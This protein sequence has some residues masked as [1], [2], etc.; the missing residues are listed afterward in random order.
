M[1]DLV[2]FGYS[3]NLRAESCFVLQ[4]ILSFLHQI[5]KRLSLDFEFIFCQFALLRRLDFSTI[6]PFY[7]FL[8]LK[9]FSFPCIDVENSHNAILIFAE[10]LIKIELLQSRLLIAFI[11]LSSLRT[12]ILHLLLTRVLLE[13]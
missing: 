8:G 2:I 5:I 11:F 7:C 13:V 10:N 12:R 4:S 9:R 3:S 1:L 6:F